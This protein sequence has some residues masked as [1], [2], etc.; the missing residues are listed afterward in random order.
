M[1]LRCKNSGEKEAL[2]LKMWED[3]HTAT[4]SRAA[5]Y[6]GKGTGQTDVGAVY[7]ARNTWP[8]GQGG[9]LYL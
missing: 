1:A 7:N 9:L 3:R 6:V 8:A 2:E 5:G 4:V